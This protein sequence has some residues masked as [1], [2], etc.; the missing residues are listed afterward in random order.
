MA[1]LFSKRSADERPLNGVTG[2]L[3]LFLAIIC[4][5]SFLLAW[6]TPALFQ[7]IIRTATES[8]R[9]FPVAGPMAFG[10]AIF[11]FI[12]L[13]AAAWGIVLTVRRSP[14]TPA[15][16]G[17]FLLA[18]FIFKAIDGMLAGILVQQVAARVS[19]TDLEAFREKAWNGVVDDLRYMLWTAIWTWYW[20][21]SERVRLTFGRNTWRKPTP[22]TAEAQ[23]AAPALS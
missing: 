7:E 17:W 1:A 23:V 15:F 11:P 4:L 2:W 16:W 5:Q 9:Q 12:F 21:N 8:W 22:P 20:N 6:E 19:P 18:I 14:S 3:A 13:V 10:E